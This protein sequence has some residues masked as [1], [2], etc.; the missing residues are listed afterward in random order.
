MSHQLTGFLALVPRP[1]REGVP[2]GQGRSPG[3][4]PPAQG[5]SPAERIKRI[6]IC[7]PQA[8]CVGE[9][10]QSRIDGL[11]LYGPAEA[12][13]GDDGEGLGGIANEIN[14]LNEQNIIPYF[15]HA[16]KLFFV[17]LQRNDEVPWHG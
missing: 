2:L 5:A 16:N 14:V 9:P 8:V 17:Y 1:R 3:G 11:L 6:I 7:F 10:Y 12:A 15:A 4:G 13:E